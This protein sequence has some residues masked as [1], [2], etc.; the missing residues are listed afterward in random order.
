MNTIKFSNIENVATEQTNLENEFFEVATIF[1]KEYKIYK[2]CNLNIF[3]TNICHNN[4]YFC[5]NNNY[6][7]TDISDEL[8]FQKLTDV[9]EEL[10]GL[11]IEITIT[12]G[13]PT[14]KKERFVKTL[15]LCKQYNLKC[16]TVSTTALNMLSEYN[17]KPLC[18]YLIENDFIHN[19]N[20]SRMDIDQIKC[21]SIFGN[22]NI[23]NDDIEKLAAFFKYND[24][25][26]RIS[27][28]LISGHIDNF[29]KMLNFVDFYR[30]KTVETIMFREIQGQ[31]DF[32]KL[33]NVVNFDDRFEYL[34][35]LNSA[36]YQVDVYKYKDM[37]VK[38]Y[39]QKTLKNNDALYALSFRNGDL[40]IGY[41][42]NKIN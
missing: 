10:R 42:N 38:Y 11:D 1:G 27:C 31:Q 22:K 23:T 26:M 37:I 15:Q 4:C 36:V 40:T 7:N 3:I 9:L 39:T 6:S 35:Q 13:E 16:R 12:G 41:S 19:I 34:K 25:E 14:I 33:Q 32:I 2:P 5:F 30:D 21:E 29:E 17:Q 20:I 18:Q 24:A 28:N 8:Y